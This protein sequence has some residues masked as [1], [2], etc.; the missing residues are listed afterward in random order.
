M[1][2]SAQVLRTGVV[3]ADLPGTYWIEISLIRETKKAIIG[4]QDTNLARVR[5]TQTYLMKCDNVF[6]IAKISRALT[7]QSLK[8][9]LYSVLA[10]HAP[11]EWEESGGKGLNLAV[12]CTKSEVSRCPYIA[13]LWLTNAHQD[14]NQKTARREFC[15]PC[16]KISPLIMEQL[17]KDIEDAKKSKNKVLKKQL[18]RKWVEQL[19]VLCSR[20]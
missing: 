4:L 8:S 14:I 9:S 18:K 10:Q 1:Y 2:L 19:S 17:D 15:G 12:V 5:A 7:D 6:I 20:S 16:K 13:K 11:V 3:L